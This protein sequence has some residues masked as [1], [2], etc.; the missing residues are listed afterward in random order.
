MAGTAG[1]ALNCVLVN[2]AASVTSLV[3]TVNASQVNTL[4]LAQTILLNNHNYFILLVA[5]VNVSQVK[6]LIHTQPPF[7]LPL[8]NNATSD[9]C[10]PGKKLD[11]HPNLSLPSHSP[12]MPL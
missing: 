1:I 5:I 6:T 12:I 9:I 8:S 11:L 3:A 4:I 7:T 10:Q 2:T